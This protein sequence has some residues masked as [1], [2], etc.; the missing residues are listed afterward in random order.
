MKKVSNTK[1]VIA[2]IVTYNRKELLKESINA[3]LKQ[4]YKNLRILIIDNNSTDGTK[5][6]ISEELKNENV[7]YENTGENLGGAGGFN[8]GM[9]L[10]AN[11]DCDYVWIMDDDCIVHK[12]SLEELMKEDERLDGNYG[13]LSS[14]VLWKDGSI[15]KMNRQRK[16][17]VGFIRDFKE[18]VIPIEMATF[19]SLL[20]KASV[21]KDVGLPIKDFFIW[22]DD[23]EYT[24]R[25]SLKYKCYLV[26]KSIV[27]HKSKENYGANIV[28][29]SPERLGRYK[30]AYRNEVYLYR[31]EGIKGMIY[32][33][34]R[35][36][37]TYLRILL[38]KNENKL[39]K[40]K[41]VN[42]STKEGKKFNPKIETV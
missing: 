32:V 17:M 7:I 1:K 38:L 27:T 33:H 42:Q 24:R 21:V 36:I 20:F 5:E 28:K 41:I 13:F 29:D 34:L 30:Y 16:S 9:K 19:V 6:H 18:D 15:C 26:G 31:R 39:E 2:V 4:N 11:M 12:D 25:I 23:L 3:L 40:I 37:Y 22:T 35:N 14:K 10:A 8:Y